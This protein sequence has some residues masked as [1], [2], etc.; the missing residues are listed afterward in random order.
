M[1]LHPAGPRRGKCHPHQSPRGGNALRVDDAARDD[2]VLQG[3]GPAGQD[4]RA[5][6]ER[7]EAAPGQRGASVAA[8]YRPHARQRLQG[9]ANGGAAAVQAEAAQSVLL[10][11]GHE[12]G[13]A[14]AA[15]TRPERPAKEQVAAFAGPTHGGQA[16]RGEQAGGVAGGAAVPADLA[17]P[18]KVP[19]DAGVFGGFGVSEAVSGGAALDQD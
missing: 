15:G 12:C 3:D 9:A 10:L 2:A 18:G 8:V 1:G 4:L 11:G 6:H 5:V 7:L 17:V 13:A 16:D 14:G 19:G